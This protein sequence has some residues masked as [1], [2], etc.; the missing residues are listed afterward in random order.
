MGDI[1]EDQ[2]IHLIVKDYKRMT[3]QHE[4]LIEV[5]KDFQ[6]QLIKKEKELADAK[7][8]LKRLKTKGMPAEKYIKDFKQQLCEMENRCISI[9]NRRTK[10]IEL[11]E[12]MITNLKQLKQILQDSK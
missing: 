7:A 8:E 12:G 1:L 5:G 9:Y 10:D 2:R 3:E 11:I 4:K 6:S